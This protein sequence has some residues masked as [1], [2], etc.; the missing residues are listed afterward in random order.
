MLNYKKGVNGYIQWAPNKMFIKTMTL[1][2]CVSPAVLI[3]I[4]IQRFTF[5]SQCFVVYFLSFS[6]LCLGMKVVCFLLLF[7]TC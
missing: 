5:G 4:E 2:A 6:F 7:D 1:K 3:L